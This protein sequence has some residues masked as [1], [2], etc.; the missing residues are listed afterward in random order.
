MDVDF[1][2]VRIPFERPLPFAW[3]EI[4]ERELL[5]LRLAGR[6][7][8]IGWGEAAPLEPYDGVS[9]AA[10]RDALEAYEPILRGGDD[11]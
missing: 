9:M 1:T 11:A 10:V 4:D 5:V 3:G 6:D 8:V 2:C 7:G